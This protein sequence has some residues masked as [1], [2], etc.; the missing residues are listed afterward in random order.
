MKTRIILLLC[1]FVGITWTQATAQD[2]ANNAE[3]G[4]FTSTYW[5]PV[6][7]DGELVDELSGGELRVHYVYRYKNGMFF[8][9]IDQLKGKV[10]SQ[11]GEVFEIRETDKYFKTDYWYVTWH[12]NLM[13]DR[14]NHYVGWITYCFF[15]GEITVGKTVC[16]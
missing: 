7:C 6:Y 15:N 11:T 13:G 10:T 4:W 8:K 9:E 12:Y 1:L 16:N 5:S 14:G 2:N 3:Q